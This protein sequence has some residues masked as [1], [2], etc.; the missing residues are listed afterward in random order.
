M[1][2]LKSFLA[3]CALALAYLSPT[4]AHAN[5][6]NNGDFSSGST[7]WTYNSSSDHPWSFGSNGSYHYASTGCVG[8]QCITGSTSQQAYLY[9]DLSTN[10]GDSYT[11][12]FAFSPNNG[13]PNELVSLFGNTTADDLVNTANTGSMLVTYTISGLVAT[14]TTT[15]LEFLGRQD[16]GY[17]LLTYVSVTDNGSGVPSPTPEPGTMMMVGT[18]LFSLAGVARRRFC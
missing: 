12:S 15:E 5:L 1:R 7:D 17:D 3:V 18:G 8:A 16:P 13:T 9:Q 10:V 2:L 14:S 6:V 4:L 11:L